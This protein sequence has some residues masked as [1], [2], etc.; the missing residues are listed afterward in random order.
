MRKFAVPMAFVAH[1]R[2]T[3]RVDHKGRPIWLMPEPWYRHVNGAPIYRGW[4]ASLVRY[5]RAQMRRERIRA[6]QKL[7]DAKNARPWV[8]SL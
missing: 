2:A 6:E 7:R 1:A 8:P 5:A 3:K 4:P